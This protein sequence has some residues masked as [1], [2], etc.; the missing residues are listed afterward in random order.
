MT[1]ARLALFSAAA[2]GLAL[3]AT[4][5]LAQTN[6]GPGTNDQ[7]VSQGYA[8]YQ[9]GYYYNGYNNGI[10]VIG[11]VVGVITAPFGVATGFGAPHPRCF[12]DR[13]FNGRYTAKCGP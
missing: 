3:S 12:A 2:I 6:P 10:P 4:P 11:P 7:A 9:G 1:H 8:P 5:S 13:D